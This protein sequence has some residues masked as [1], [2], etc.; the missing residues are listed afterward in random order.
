MVAI[1]AFALSGCSMSLGSLG[2]GDAADEVVTGS[3][4]APVTAPV[5]G[6]TSAPLPAPGAT[7][8]LDGAATGGAAQPP[9]NDHDWGYAR[10]ALSLALTGDNAGPPVPWAN[11]DTGTRGNFAPSAPAATSA[12]GTTCREFRATRVE[13]GREVR[14]LGR[15]CKDAGGQWVISETRRE[16]M[17]S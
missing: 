16:A 2:G 13:G 8:A 14:L 12:E 11:P 1:V 10:G 3:I 5:T 4:P 9:L 15:A 6:V 17:P 7:A